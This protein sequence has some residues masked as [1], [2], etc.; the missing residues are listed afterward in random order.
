MLRPTRIVLGALLVALMMAMLHLAPARAQIAPE[1]D[2]N[3][4]GRVNSTDLLVVVRGLDGADVNHDGRVDSLDFDIVVSAIED[5]MALAVAS[6]TPTQRT[7]GWTGAYYNNISLSG[8]VAATRQD[9]PV[10]AFAWPGSPAAG[11]NAD[12]FSVR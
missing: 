6:A 2:A 1:P 11:V 4:D 12:Y 5:A 9:G 10:L 8:G 3:G 7:S